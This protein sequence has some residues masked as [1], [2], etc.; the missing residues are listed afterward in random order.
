M[1]DDAAE[2]IVRRIEQG[3]NDVEKEI[4]EPGITPMQAAFLA[5]RLTQLWCF[6]APDQELFRRIDTLKIK[7]WGLMAP[8]GWQVS[9]GRTDGRPIPEGL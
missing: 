1:S 8:R 2:K 5:G 4:A 9:D 6:A 3:L 7:A